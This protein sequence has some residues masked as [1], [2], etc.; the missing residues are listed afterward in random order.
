[1]RS[2]EASSYHA[3]VILLIDSIATSCFYDLLWVQWMVPTKPLAVFGW[4][5]CFSAL[6]FLGL[7]G[8]YTLLGDFG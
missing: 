5:S 7:D 3:L 1:M 2:I 4:L 8:L 6:L